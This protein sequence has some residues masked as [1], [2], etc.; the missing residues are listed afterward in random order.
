MKSIYQK[1]ITVLG[2]TGS[3]GTQ[4]LDV[5][6]AQSVKVDAICGA[7][8]ISLLEEQIRE[9]SPE[10]CAVLDESAAK[11]L[12]IKVA[13][14]NCQII[15]GYD[16]II[17]L[18]GAAKSDSVINSITGKAGLAPSV[19]AIRSGVTLALANKETIVCAGSI[20]NRLAKD[21]NVKVLPV[22]SEHSAIF[23]CIGESRHKDI[24]KLILTASGGPFFGKSREE[25][26]GITP[27][28][29]LAHPTWKMGPKITIDS[30][31]LMNKGFEV[32]EA[33]YL[34]DVSADMIDVVV[35]P[36]SIVHSMVEYID[37]AV[38]AQLSCPDMR[39]CVQYALSYPVR[40]EG[41][42]KP[43]DLTELGSLTFKKPDK[44]TFKLL[45]LAY[46]VLRLGGNTGA[47]LN[48]ANERAVALFLD[49]KIS[50]TDIMDLVCEAVDKITFIEEPT[51]ADID[52]T[53][54][55]SRN[56]IDE[57]IRS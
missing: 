22:D 30:A 18:A 23:Q 52:R 50:F 33:K 11:D 56:I 39:L 19:A 8:S 36:E 28:M 47:A 26:N 13:D 4:A 37:N 21:N 7:K 38:I 34:F 10:V 35:H 48:G 42:L 17:E 40:C 12:K 57:L 41:T 6:R 24:K 25:L 54:I 5:A 20:V 45:D 14:T 46:K 27:E 1:S 29:A 55:E 32:I 53:D 2:S 49:K 43:L 31:T 9:F 44:K 3:V 16:A 15:S 51:L